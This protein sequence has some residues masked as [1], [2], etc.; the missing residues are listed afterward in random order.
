MQ[1]LAEELVG[2]GHQVTVVTSYPKYNLS[3]E[4]ESGHYR[5][6]SDENGVQVIRVKTLP[7]HMVNFI[8]RGIAQLTMPYLFLRK[9]RKYVK[10]RIDVVFAYSPPITLG[11]IGLWLKEKKDTRF[12][13]NVQDI[14]PQN[15]IDL[16][17]LKNRL[18]IKYFEYI[19][20]TLYRHANNVV[21]HSEGNRV[22]LVSQKKVSEER[23]HVIHN[24]VDVSAYTATK[25]TGRF[26]KAYGLDDRFILLFAGVIG[27][28]QGLDL[29]IEVARRIPSD[30]NICFLFVGD[31][32][33]KPKLE[34]AVEK[35]GLTN[36][37]FKP[38]VSKDEYIELVKDADVGLVCLT[39]ENKTPVVPGKILGYM[40]A[41][42]PTAAFLQKQS[43]GHKMI[44]DSKC[45]YSIVSDSSEKALELIMKM[46]EQ[47]DQ[48]KQLG[49]NGQKYVAE[50][51]SI[52][53][54]VE[55]IEQVFQQ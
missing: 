9:I 5:E 8:I 12:V 48:I 45:G 40:A 32:T 17:I 24:W 38:F 41:G 49:L 33:E 16:G 2:R 1:E 42:I 3:K 23:V 13:L 50:T 51:F 18:L 11:H 31:G 20:K 39:S 27:P 46:Y 10:N 25:S 19:E 44:E 36:V 52:E 26:R 14:F 7:H 28:S 30:C 22:F 47:R 6:F 55:K 15:A 21:V 53:K 4:I 43:D 37:V 35:Y 29:L 34:Q 54:A